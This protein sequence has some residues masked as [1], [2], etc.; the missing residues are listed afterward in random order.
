MR[1]QSKTSLQ[2]YVS[3]FDEFPFPSTKKVISGGK[4]G[5]ALLVKR[6][7]SELLKQTTIGRLSALIKRALTDQIIVHYKTYIIKHEAP[8]P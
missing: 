7:G 5:C 8:S 6:F 3:S 2:S 4:Y 1:K